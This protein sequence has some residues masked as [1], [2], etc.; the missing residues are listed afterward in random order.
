MPRIPLP[1]P[2]YHATRITFYSFINSAE[3]RTSY[4]SEVN[5]ETYTADVP[6]GAWNT[7]DDRLTNPDARVFALDGESSITFTNAGEQL[8]FII[9]IDVIEAPQEVTMGAN[10]WATAI[11]TKNL[12]FSG[13][14]G[15]TA[16]T[17][18]ESAGVVTLTKVNDVPAGTGVVLK[19]D[20]STKYEVP[21]IY[22]S[23]TDAGAL[24]GSATATTTV[25]GDFDF[26]G[27]TWNGS[28]AQFAKINA[29]QVIPAGKAFLKIAA[30]SARETLDI[31]F[32][33]NETTGIENVKAAAEDG[34]VYNL[35]GV[36][37][38][39]P[40]K[41]LYIVNGKKMLVK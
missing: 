28:K 18:T 32:A 2:G 7:V 14:A 21:A 37:V 17:A 29:G 26:Y 11:A 4:W 6:M 39:Q 13:V 31:V 38:A 10:G 16:Y 41:G 1:F 22:E 15:L 20:N 23:T 27:L 8:C 9:A 30:A 24:Q 19:G 34:A 12:D 40:T 5:G 3:A 25:E 36:R 33:G 35:Q